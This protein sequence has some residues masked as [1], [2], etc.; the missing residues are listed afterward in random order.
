MAD[1]RRD[2]TRRKSHANSPGISRAAFE[3]LK[4][5]VARLGFS[6][7]MMPTSDHCGALTLAPSIGE[8][9]ADFL[10]GEAEM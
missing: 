10:P 1:A 9:P 6:C 8:V 3:H 7:A 2:H 4:Y 5:D